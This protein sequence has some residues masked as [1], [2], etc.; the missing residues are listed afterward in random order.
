[1]PA[2]SYTVLRSIVRVTFNVTLKTDISV[3]SS[4]SP[5]VNTFS[6]VAGDF[7]GLNSG[8]WVFV[9]G[10]TNSANNGWHQLSLNSTSSLITVT[11]TLIT[12][13]AGVVVS[14]TGYLYGF[15]E[16]VS[17]DIRVSVDNRQKQVIKT[18]SKSL[19]G[20]I[21]T[22]TDDRKTFYN[23]TTGVLIPADYKFMI[24]FLDSCESGEAFTWDRDGTLA[25][26]DLSVSS[27]LDSNG[28]TEERLENI[29]DRRIS[30]RIRT[31]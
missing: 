26:P 20:S 14:F 4:G 2:L 22:L 28:Y 18:E 29:I 16:L 21:E 24:Q 23:I 27:Y 6:S 7:S 17:S 30:F 12:E 11:S 15:G 13:L 25:S 31:A 1:M 8:E 3:S 9:E 10:F 19:D 5:L